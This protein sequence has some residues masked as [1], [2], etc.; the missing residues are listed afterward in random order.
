[1]GVFP[2]IE[3]EGARGLREHTQSLVASSTSFATVF[4][5]RAVPAFAA[6][7]RSF[8]RPEPLGYAA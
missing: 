1:M 3:L 5:F 8:V 7:M 4:M 6:G 2:D